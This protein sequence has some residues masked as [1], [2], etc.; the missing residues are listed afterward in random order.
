MNMNNEILKLYQALVKKYGKLVWWTHESA[1]EIMLGAILVQNTNW[2]NAEKALLCLKENGLFC[3]AK[4]ANV[5][6]DKLIQHIKPA[7]LY[8][9]K[10]PRIKAICLWYKDELHFEMLKKKKTETLRN[11]LLSIKGIGN[12]TADAILLYGLKRPTFVVDAY[13]QRLLMKLGIIEKKMEYLQLQSIFHN[14]LPKKHLLYSQYHALIVHHSQ[15]LK[16]YKNKECVEDFFQI[17]KNKI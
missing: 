6:I 9:Q 14:S 12:E 1:F 4:I 15:Q 8:N 11:E 16:K 13:S 5:S 2:N 3:A 17:S 10:A 7:G